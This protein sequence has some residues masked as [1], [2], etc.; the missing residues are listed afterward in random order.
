MWKKLRLISLLS[1]VS[2]LLVSCGT[3]LAP[4]DA[5]KPLG[6]QINYT[7][8][9]IDAGAGIMLSTQNAI[10][11]YKLDDYNWQ[12]QTS[13]TAAMTSTLEKAIKDKR[14]I[15]VTGW[16]PHWMFTKFDLKFLDDPK[17]VY[18]D[19]EDIHT[20]V[21]KGLKKDMPSAYAVLDNFNWTPEEMSKVMLEVND[22]ADPE[23][24]A[25]KWVKNNP[26]KVAEWTKGVQKVNGD[27]IKLTYVAWDSE[28]ASTNV[29]AEVLRSVGYKP[30]I[31]AMEIQPMWASV[32]TGAADGMVA[33]W[34]PN[35]AG[36]YY[37][38]YKSDIED[39]GINLKGA[40]VG[41]AVPTYMKN[42][43]SI[44]DLKK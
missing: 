2:L 41:L 20:I 12:L 35:T 15:V 5:K 17:N 21:R 25:K 9:G 36:V 4:Y 27:K 1:I 31:Q 30:T 18:G 14:P 16:T 26:D 24:A 3:E 37:K 40:K 39:L 11:A 38:D 13:S 8:T 23:E 7:I 28:I 29:V 6:E 43:N 32:A 33:A 44:E 42:I 19:A 10:K 34:L 22:G